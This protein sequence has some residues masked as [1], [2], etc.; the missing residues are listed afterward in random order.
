MHP[1]T[2]KFDNENF[3][4][5]FILSAMNYDYLNIDSKTE[6]GFTYLTFKYDK[7]ANKNFDYSNIESVSYYCDLV[8]PYTTDDIKNN[9]IDVAVYQNND[10]VMLDPITLFV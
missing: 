6:L 1:N 9:K 7:K 4:N 8:Y 2:I 10:G 5:D 3:D